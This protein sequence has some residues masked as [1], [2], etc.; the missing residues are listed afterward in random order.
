MRN[1]P[2]AYTVKTGIGLPISSW[3]TKSNALA[4][5]REWYRQRRG[6]EGCFVVHNATGNVVWERLPKEKAGR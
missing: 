5:S 2:E 6:T 4:A 3:A 1:A